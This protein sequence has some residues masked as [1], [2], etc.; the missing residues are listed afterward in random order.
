MN[1]SLENISFPSA[2]TLFADQTVE[3][4]ADGDFI[5]LAVIA[6]QPGG[7]MAT[8]GQVVLTRHVACLALQSLSG[9]VNASFKVPKAKQLKLV[10][11]AS[12]AD[13]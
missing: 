2:I 9:A 5:R 6:R 12:R 10:K 1:G 4:E 8:V 11:V 13:A 7:G 3:A